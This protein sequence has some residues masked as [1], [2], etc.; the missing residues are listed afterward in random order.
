MVSANL[1]W[2]EKYYASAIQT[3]DATGYYAYLPAVLIYHDL[4]FTY[5]DSVIQKH[6]DLKKYYD[7]RVTYNGKTIN[8]YYAGTALTVFPFFI[9][10]HFYAKLFNFTAD[11]FSIPYY[12]S[13]NIAS[14]IFLIIGLHYVK[15]LLIWYQTDEKIIFFILVVLVWGTN[16]FYYAASEPC[17]SHIYSFA[18]VSGF[19]YHAKRFFESPDRKQLFICAL[20]LGVIVLIRPINGIVIFSLPF[21]AG[22][23]NSL[24][25]AFSWLAK[26]TIS[27]VLS[28]IFFLSIISIQLIIYK[29]QCGSFFVYSYLGE[30]FNW[31]NPQIINFLFSYKKGFFLYTPVALI[32][33]SG[34]IFL[35]RKNRFEFY[36]LVLFLCFLVYV[37]SSWWNWWYGGSFSSRVLM[38]FYVFQALLLLFSYRIAEKNIKKSIIISVCLLVIIICQIQAY[39]YR[40]DIIINDGMTKEQYWDVFLRVDRLLK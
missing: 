26:N 37:L 38:D 36:S 32:S 4:N 21:V 34:Y 12:I 30:G 10:G 29:I 31:T 1:H 20:F 9:A 2:S 33:I 27:I 39:Q 7:Y 15:K 40:Y 25:T 16:L 8:K 17:L 18:F 28:A 19:V 6:Y 3:N 14:I 11:G 5:H 24:N 13:V 23:F 22:S 35:W